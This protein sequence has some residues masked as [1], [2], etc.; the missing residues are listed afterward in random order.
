[1][2]LKVFQFHIFHEP[3]GCIN[4]RVIATSC[5]EKYI[6]QQLFRIRNQKIQRKQ[7]IFEAISSHLHISCHPM[8]N[9]HRIILLILDH[10]QDVSTVQAIQEVL[11]DMEPLP[12]NRRQTQHILHIHPAVPPLAPLVVVSHRMKRH[13]EALIPYRLDSKR[14]MILGQLNWTV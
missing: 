4:Q 7:Q 1:M 14:N 3:V 6:F 10:I 13:Q 8:Q 12:T 11:A 2:P 5:L 9:Q